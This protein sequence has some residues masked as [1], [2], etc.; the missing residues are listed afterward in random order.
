MEVA[1]PLGQ[2]SSSQ[3]DNSGVFIAY[4]VAIEGIVKPARCRH[5]SEMRGEGRRDG[6]PSKSWTRSENTRHH[7][8]PQGPSILF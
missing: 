7:V 8:T 6:S 5:V 2:L 4:T 1:P 3:G